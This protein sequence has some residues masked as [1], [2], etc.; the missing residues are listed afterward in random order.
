MTAHL[1]AIA[2]MM[3]WTDR[4]YR[5]LMRCLT[6][7]TLLYTEMVHANAMIHG[8]IET[9]QPK[10]AE[11]S[12]VALQLGGSE[13]ESLSRAARLGE[14][15]G[16]DEINLNV[17][18]PSPRV[19]SGSFGA[20]L[21][22][23]PPLVAECVTAMQSAVTIPVTVK[24]R[25]GVDDVD[26]Y[27]DLVNFI[28]T[29]SRTGCDH[30]IIHARKALLKG[31]SPKENRTVPPLHYDR[32]YQLKQD[33]PE[34]AITINGGVTDHAAIESHLTQVDGVMLGRVAYHQPYLLAEVDQRYYGSSDPISSREQMI[35]DYYPY[36]EAQLSKGVNL[37]AMTR[38]MLHLYHGQPKAR[39]WRRILTEQARERHAGI[40]VIERALQ[41]VK[42]DGLA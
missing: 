33:F 11:E 20:C 7:R 19:Q 40:E 14:A 3:D 24:C 34:L 36:I 8:Q 5:V 23:E 21:M 2:P 37:Y 31:L 35:R 12:P 13:P 18:C 4:H 26:R 1:I 6:Q 38:H 41:S 39:H 17:G 27:D 42:V 15:L 22:K 30:F 29:V 28:E 25:I 32:V 10:H 16:F 9:N